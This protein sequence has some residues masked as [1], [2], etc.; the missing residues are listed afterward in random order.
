[1]FKKINLQQL[2]RIILKE[3]DIKLIDNTLKKYIDNKP[4]LEKKVSEMPIK[5]S[6]KG[7]YELKLN[8]ENLNPTMERAMELA[9]RKNA[10]ISDFLTQVFYYEF[11]FENGFVKLG[12][13]DEKGIAFYIVKHDLEMN[14]IETQI[15]DKGIRKAIN[16]KIDVKTS[17][18]K[19]AKSM[20]AQ[21]TS[22]I[23]YSQLMA[24]LNEESAII[25]RQ[26][27]IKGYQPKKLTKKQRE[28]E[29]RK[30]VS[31]S[32]PK[33]EYS[34][35][36]AERES[37]KRPYERV[38]ESWEVEGHWRTYKKSGK[39]VFVKGYKKGCGN[40]SAKRKDFTV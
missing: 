37:G 27:H 38:V 13:I 6:L 14:Y 24:Y 10:N 5:V 35:N 19:V 39:R 15:F 11:D 29:A 26:T 33:V 7:V 16:N 8:E 36:E 12:E 3:S 25:K 34:Y 32:K 30:R 40:T 4:K 1:M 22:F 23:K 28:R 2:D 20:L 17:L 18:Q 31:V 21:I 9:K